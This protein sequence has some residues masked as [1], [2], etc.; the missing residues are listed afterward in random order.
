STA[1]VSDPFRIRMTSA[2]MV[3]MNR[4]PESQTRAVGMVRGIGASLVGSGDGFGPGGCPGLGADQPVDGQSLLGLEGAGDLAGLRAVE[5]VRVDGP[6]S[7]T[8]ALLPAAQVGAVG[9][10]AGHARGWAAP[11]PEVP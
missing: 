5:A 8:H 7:V 1:S 2:V 6:A 11:G 4:M 3:E 9:V 10:V